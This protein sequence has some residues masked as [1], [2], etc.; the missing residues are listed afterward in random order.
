MPPRRSWREARTTSGAARG[1]SEPDNR[2]LA[3]PRIVLH[4]VRR[5][6][7]ARVVGPED[8]DADVGGL[9]VLEQGIKCPVAWPEDI[10]VPDG[11]I[12]VIHQLRL[13]RAADGNGLAR[14]ADKDS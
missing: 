2:Y 10:L 4:A 9:Q 6:S 3:A 5:L 12:E 11:D 8:E 1:R 14:A 13:D 7:A